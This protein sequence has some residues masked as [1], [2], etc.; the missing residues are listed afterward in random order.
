MRKRE[1]SVET[2][3]RYCLCAAAGMR[4]ESAMHAESGFQREATPLPRGLITRHSRTHTAGVLREIPS[5]RVQSLSELR[6]PNKMGI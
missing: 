2:A 1:Q 4:P 5:I 6:A 3:F